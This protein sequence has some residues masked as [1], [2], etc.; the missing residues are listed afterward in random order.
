[1]SSN[2]DVRDQ[3]ASVIN[4]TMAATVDEMVTK[5]VACIETIDADGKRALWLLS[6][7]TAKP[8]DTLGLLTYAVQQEQGMASVW[9]DIDVE[10]DD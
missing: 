6:D 4:D 10:G 2:E 3:V 8:W 7:P 9:L 5:W 1:M